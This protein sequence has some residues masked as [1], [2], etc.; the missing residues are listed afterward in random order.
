MAHACRLALALAEIS[1]D[2]FLG[3]LLFGL[4]EYLVGVAEFDQVTRPGSYYR[5][6]SQE[7]QPKYIPQR[8][9]D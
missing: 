2:V 9:S 1:L 5:R 3:F 8:T 7:L 4:I 6:K